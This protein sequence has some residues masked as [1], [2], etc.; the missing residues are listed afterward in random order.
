MARQQTILG[1][2]DFIARVDESVGDFHTLE[3]M[4]YHNFLQGASV[5]FHER[6]IGVIRE[7][8]LPVSAWMAEDDFFVDLLYATLTAWGMDSGKAKLQDFDRFNAAVRNL[9]ASDI[10]QEL[11]G[12]RIAEVDTNWHDRLQAIWGL[13]EGDSRIMASDSVLVGASK[14]LHHLVPDLFPPMDRKYTLYLMSHV[15]RKDFKI[16]TTSAQHPDFEVFYRTMLFCSY[17]ARTCPDIERHVILDRP[18]SGSVPKVID[19]AIIA[20]VAPY[21]VRS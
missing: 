17:A 8:S 9:A 16:S 19:N 10:F 20:Y 2:A 21:L 14:L 12:H 7:R 3:D 18:M 1:L 4:P 6:V 5:H 15:N 11:E 13:L